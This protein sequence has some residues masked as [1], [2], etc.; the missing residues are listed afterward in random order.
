M[1]ETIRVQERSRVLEFSF[2]DLMRYHGPGS[3][4]GVANAF[5]VLQR[6]FAELFPD[7]P[8]PR[9]SVV[10][11][12][13]F[14]G[15]GARDGVE[16]VTRAVSDGRYIVDPALARPDLGRLRESFVF[17]VS[18][19]GESVTL[20]LRDG[21]VTEEFIDLAQKDD[22][23]D[24]EESRLDELKAQLAQRIMA[25]DAAGVYDVVS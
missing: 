12:T 1:A 2:E 4:G 18:I 10:V 3:P 13:S 7:E 25:A 24:A 17:E 21:F 23:T 9:R 16:A 14:R 22:R 15:P 20:V 8:P 6:A 19:G 11:R 5:K